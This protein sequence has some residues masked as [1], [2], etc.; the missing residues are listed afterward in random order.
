MYFGL[1][2]GW[3]TMGS[4]QS[5]LLGFGLFQILRSQGLGLGFDAAENVIVQTTAVATATM[6]LA[7]GFVGIIPAFSQ[8]TPEENPPSGGFELSAPQLA[9][10]SCALAFFGVFFAVPLRKQVIQREKLPFPSGTAT[11][12]VIAILHGKRLTDRGEDADGS[13]EDE[14]DRRRGAPAG[15]GGGVQRADAASPFAEREHCPELPPRAEAPLSLRP[16]RSCSGD[17]LCHHHTIVPLLTQ[18]H[19]G[20]PQEALDKL[21]SDRAQWGR[22]W[23]VLLWSMLGTMAASVVTFL[24]PGLGRFPVFDWAGLRGASAWGWELIPAFG[25]VGQG[26]IMGP[27]TT[28]S[29]LC[30]AIVGYAVLG[31]HARRE[32]WAPGPI[33][34]WET[35]ASGWVLWVSLAVM[36][37]DSLTSLALLA[38]SYA[39]SALADAWRGALRRAEGYDAADGDIVSGC[40]P[41][42]AAW[43]AGGLAA[44]T[45]LCAAVLAPMFDMAAWAP[46]A[47]AAVAMLVAVLAIRAL[48]ETDLNPVSGVGKLSQII[49]G[50]IL[51]GNV[52]ANLVAG[53][54]AEA[55]AQQAGDMMQDFKTAQLLGVCPRAQFFCM[56]I[57]S[58]ASVVTSVLAYMLY[59][60]AFEVPSAAFPV[61]TAQ[62]WLSM[63][64]LVN[65]GELLPHV[66][67]FSVYFGAAAAAL[68]LLASG[69]RWLAD[70]GGGSAPRQIAPRAAEAVL[71]WLPSGVGFA[72]GMYVSPKF[73][74]P[75]VVGS[76]LEQAWLRSRRTSH[77]DLMVVCA[78]G[79]VLGEGTASLILAAAKSALRA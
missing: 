61:P 73:T 44:S 22:T 62:I 19:S 31:P 48:G 23:A 76:V 72:V 29:M 75:R 78:S 49:F 36:L 79:L 46:A 52:V 30:G 21:D 54:V 5:A 28:A 43:W 37:G 66:R 77:Q 8:L 11:A 4:L 65:G 64:R 38:A 1:Q 7:A 15:E 12:E 56:L 50:A 34:D 14:T 55:G 39:G 16:K 13:S 67:E 35:G 70:A 6:P 45:A 59:T 33:Q 68:P 74:L 58:A 51:P 41:I 60:S 32:G 26:M 27:R 57:G 71:A 69:L 53:A 47:A 2:T 3:V 40:Q 42:P 10:W 63:A 20:L 25:Y 18:E 17:A 24:V 9:A